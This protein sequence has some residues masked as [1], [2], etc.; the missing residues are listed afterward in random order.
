MFNTTL[1]EAGSILVLAPHPDDEAL[2]CGGT[3][4]LLTARGITITV[5]HVTTGERLH[6]APSPAVAAARAA[7]A[8]TVSK[9]LGC[10]ECLFL[11]FPDGD[12]RGQAEDISREVGGI[13]TR[14]RP[15][16]VFAPS[17]LDHHADHLAL[18]H[19]ALALSAE[20]KGPQFVLYEVYS[21]I[22]FNCLV[23]ITEVIQKKQKAISEYRSSLYGKPELYVHAA[24]GLNAHRSIF[25]QRQGYFEAFYVVAQNSQPRVVLDYLTYRT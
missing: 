2:G 19:I 21:T 20:M 1:P 24:L 4:S 14:L 13:I 3:I 10:R 22:R 12:I 6:G 5:C 16:L 11:D 15:D 23:D 8:Q 25:T 7:E 18:A 17:P 9:L